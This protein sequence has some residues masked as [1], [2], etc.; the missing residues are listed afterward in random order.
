MKL[1]LQGR[2][3]EA[4]DMSSM[5]SWTKGVLISVFSL[6]LLLPATAEENARVWTSADGRKLT[7]TLEDK[8]DD[9]VKIKVKGKVYKLPLEKLSKKDQAF[10]KSFVIKRPLE[11]NVK[12]DSW[13]GILSR[14]EL[15][16][17]SM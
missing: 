14:D 12:V 16:V 2:L 7:G 6:L 1:T 8:G 15:S 3:P 10:V 11:V 13:V 5:T 17:K 9:W 4:N